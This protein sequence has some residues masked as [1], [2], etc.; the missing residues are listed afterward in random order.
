MTLKDFLPSPMRNKILISSWQAQTFYICTLYNSRNTEWG[1]NLRLVLMPCE[2]IE[3]PKIWGKKERIK[4]TGQGEETVKWTFQRGDKNRKLISYF[5][6]SKKINQ[7]Q[8]WDFRFASST[9]STV[10]AVELLWILV[11]YS[12]SRFSQFLSA[13]F[14]HLINSQSNAEI[15][16]STKSVKIMEI[17]KKN[18]QYETDVKNVNI[19]KLMGATEGHI[20]LL[21]GKYNGFKSVSKTS[22]LLM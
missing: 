3:F 10:F 18:H 4:C 2:L 6:K 16:L 8:S 7:F 1:K 11:P 13:H 15:I 22:I 5:A 9:R 20:I 17:E 12:F 19:T 14:F 21:L